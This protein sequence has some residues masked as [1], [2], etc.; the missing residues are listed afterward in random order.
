MSGFPNSPRLIKGGIVL[1][2]PDSGTV[3]KIIVLQYNPDTLTRTLMPQGVTEGSDRSEA[4]RLTGSPIE[5]IKLDA[6]IDATDQLEVADQRGDRRLDVKL[7]DS[8][9]NAQRPTL[10]AQASVELHIEQ[11]VLDGFASGDRYVIG[12]AVERELALL[13]GEQDIPNLLRFDNATDEIKGQTF[14]VPH[15][16]KPHAMG[17][18]IARAVYQGFGK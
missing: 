4:L 10:N 7:T 2:D 15:N 17:R 9:S 3:Q 5:T 11:L 6:E 18:R 13:F 8:T 12:E 1:V 14:I 16:A